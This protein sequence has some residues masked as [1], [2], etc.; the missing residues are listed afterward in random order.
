MKCDMKALTRGCQVP[1]RQDT[2][3]IH[4]GLPEGG[5]HDERP[6]QVSLWSSHTAFFL[7]PCESCSAV[8]P[9]W[10]PASEGVGL[11]PEGAPVCPP[12][13]GGGCHQGVH[14]GQRPLHPAERHSCEAFHKE[15]CAARGWNLSTH[16]FVSA[17]CT[18]KLVG[19]PK[20]CQAQ[21]RLR[22]DI[23]DTRLSRASD[24]T[25]TTLG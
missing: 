18:A 8:R 13:G 20:Q 21:P 23:D 22:P 3:P 6:N 17:A 14:A 7:R 24:L 11:S 25:L 9:Y 19:S 4:N 15:S 5:Q 16:V 2:W 1:V 12:E 10:G